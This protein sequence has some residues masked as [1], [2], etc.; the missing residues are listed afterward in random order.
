MP[1]HVL[2]SVLMKSLHKFVLS[3]YIFPTKENLVETLKHGIGYDGLMEDMTIN[4]DDW[5][6]RNSCCPPHL[7]KPRLMIVVVVVIS[8]EKQR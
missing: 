4:R 2:R 8:F 5:R 3:T 1:I 7:V 6:S